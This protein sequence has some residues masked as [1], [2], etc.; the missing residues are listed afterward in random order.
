M[1]VEHD[2][3]AE[4]EQD[5]YDPTFSREFYAAKFS[6][7]KDFIDREWDYMVQARIVPAISIEEALMSDQEVVY[8]GVNAKL[9]TL[10]E[11]ELRRARQSARFMEL[12]NRSGVATYELWLKEHQAEVERD[13]EVLSGVEEREWVQFTN[14]QLQEAA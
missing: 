4:F 13:P 10:A 14:Q 11:L 1:S 3:I 12:M 8:D 5:A 6:R 7:E 9:S 2:M